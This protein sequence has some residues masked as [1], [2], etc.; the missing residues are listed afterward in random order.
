[1][2]NKLLLLRLRFSSTSSSSS[3]FWY[4]GSGADIFKKNQLP[5][6]GDSYFFRALDFTRLY[7]CILNSIR[8]THPVKYLA[9]ILTAPQLNLAISL[10]WSWH[11]YG[12]IVSYALQIVTISHV[13]NWKCTSVWPKCLVSPL[14]MWKILIKFSALSVYEIDSGFHF[15][16]Y[17]YKHTQWQV[18]CGDMEAP[19]LQFNWQFIVFYCTSW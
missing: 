3:T 8:W 14:F 16:C 9:P 17:I 2:L 12:F 13:N 19:V 11:R 7:A 15:N 6:P 18:Y 10:P 4:R 5:T 1:M